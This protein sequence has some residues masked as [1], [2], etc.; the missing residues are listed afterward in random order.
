MKIDSVL[1]PKHMVWVSGSL[2]AGLLLIVLTRSGAKASVQAPLP[3]VEV[4]T[5]EQRDVPVYGEWIGTLTGQVNADV[6]AQ[7]T[8][9]LLTRKYKEGSYVRKGELLFEIDP[10]PFQAALDQAKA[11]L[12][13]AKAQLVQDQAQR[14]AAQANKQMSQLNVD[15]YAPLAAVDAVSKQDFD[16]A[17]QTNLANKNQGLAA[18]AAI[19][20]AEAQIQASEAGVE[21]AG[22][23]LGFTR[24]VSPIDGIA[25]IAQAQVG[26]L[27]NTSSGVLTTVST[28]DPIR[29]YFAVSEQEYLALAEANLEP[30]QG[31]LEAATH[32]RRWNHLFASGLLFCG[33]TGKPKYRR[34]SIGGS[35]CESRKC[36]PPRAVWQG[37][38]H[39]PRAAERHA[40][41]PGCREPGAGQLSRCCC[42]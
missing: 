12:A 25:G 31:S 42:R 22:I 8:G 37:P 38:R 39:D 27:V 35:V 29:D 3:I 10:R 30:R 26:D 23:N 4:A 19:A 2:L 32:P 40:H 33:S 20:S 14:A 15:K 6:K 13:Q 17:D 34:N 5:V 28:V 9:Y 1:K 36:S 7:V 16:N 24:I 11:Q 21:T 18:E 41:S